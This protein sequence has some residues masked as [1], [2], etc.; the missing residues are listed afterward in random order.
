M[1]AFGASSLLSYNNP[2]PQNLIDFFPRIFVRV[3]ATKD[4]LPTADLDLGPHAHG[5]VARANQAAVM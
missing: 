1:L 4:P 5:I 2:K 3:Q